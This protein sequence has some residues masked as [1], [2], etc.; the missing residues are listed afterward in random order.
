MKP[1]VLP[2]R[3]SP[4]P[5]Q[6]PAERSGVTICSN[7]AERSRWYWSSSGCALI[8]APKSARLAASS[9]SVMVSSPQAL[10]PVSGWRGPRSPNPCWTDFTCMSYQLAQ[11]VETMPPWWVMSRYQS[12]APSQTHMA[13]RAGGWSDATCHWLIP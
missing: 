11:K 1:S 10:T 3:W 2:R 5:P 13:A 7:R 4:C 6:L 12:A 9:S 8:S